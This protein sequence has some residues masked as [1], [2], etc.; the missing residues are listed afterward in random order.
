ML[1]A[2]E[3]EYQHWMAGTRKIFVMMVLSQILQ[4]LTHEDFGDQ[5]EG[6]IKL[7]TTSGHM[8]GMHV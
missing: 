1:T 5:D 4:I 3:T 2:L 6:I 8:P 7:K